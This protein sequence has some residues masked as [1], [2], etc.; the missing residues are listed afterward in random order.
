M[1]LAVVLFGQWIMW[2]CLGYL[3]P[4]SAVLVVELEPTC[5]ILTFVSV[6]PDSISWT[7]WFADAAVNTLVW[8]YHQHVVALVETIH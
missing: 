2:S 6:W 3:R 7:F 8:V 4:C 5:E 1:R